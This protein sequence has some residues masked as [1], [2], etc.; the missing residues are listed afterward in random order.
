MVTD[1]HFF[2]NFLAKIELKVLIP[3]F[4]ETLFPNFIYAIRNKMVVITFATPNTRIMNII[5][6]NWSK[7]K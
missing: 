4:K 6:L 3:V 2:T 7:N 1:I 5:Q